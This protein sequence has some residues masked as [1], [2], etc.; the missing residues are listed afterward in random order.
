MRDTLGKLPNPCAESLAVTHDLTH[1]GDMSLRATS[2]R[3]TQLAAS[4]Q[5]PGCERKSAIAIVVNPGTVSRVC[6]WCGWESTTVLAD[7][8]EVSP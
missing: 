2:N 7:L 4:R 3:P 5:C 1:N 6:R 8:P